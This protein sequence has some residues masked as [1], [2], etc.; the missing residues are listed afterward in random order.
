MAGSEA[1][2]RIRAKV[3]AALRSEFPDA[4]IVHEVNTSWGG[5]RMD[6]AAVRP[7][8][9]TLV[10]IK[11]ERDV[12]KRL[13]DQIAAA[14]K[15]TGDVRIYAA[16]KH[17]P[18]LELMGRSSLGTIWNEDR[19]IGRNDPNPAYCPD[20]HKCQVLIETEEGFTSALDASWWLRRAMEHAPD[21]RALLE[22]LW[23]EE[24]RDLLIRHSLGA[25]PKATRT[26]TKMMAQENLT[27][28]QVREGVCAALRARPFARADGAAA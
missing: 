18:A 14:L 2:E 20:L 8:A 9:L 6:L 27:G 28:R 26:V 15:I 16:E 17:A 12:L 21:P 1:E 22:M 24:L 5:V 23:A 19:T 13:S 11:S 4:R 10:E 25:P 7:N 3:E